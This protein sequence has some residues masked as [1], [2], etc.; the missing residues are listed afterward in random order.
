MEKIKYQKKDEIAKNRQL[1]QMNGSFTAYQR[2]A[3]N[4]LLK[5]S[6]D[7]EIKGN[8]KKHYKMPLSHFKATMGYKKDSLTLQEI[9]NPLHDLQSK[10][11]M[12]LTGHSIASSSLL[13]YFKLDEK[14]R[15]LQWKLTKAVRKILLENR[16]VVLDLA[17]INAMKSSY[18]IALYEFLKNKHINKK[19]N[20]Y[21][22]INLTIDNFREIMGINKKQYAR[23]NNL[24]ARV[25][26]KAIREINDKS[27]L[28]IYL[29]PL[30]IGTKTNELVFHFAKLSSTKK[31]KTIELEQKIKKDLQ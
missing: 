19:N 12:E 17:T 18:A 7:Q 25:I 23:F 20:T 27:D 30:K 1:I 29:E 24:K 13:P 16:Y 14:K 15:T 5:T 2:K 11:F 22:E 21:Q 28:Y 9:S 4:L 31:Q 8:K 10:S 6:I 3:L 26:D